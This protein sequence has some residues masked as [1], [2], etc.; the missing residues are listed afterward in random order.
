MTNKPN[1]N[2]NTMVEL[3]GKLL[4]G[5]NSVSGVVHVI[6]D[7]SEVDKFREGEILVADTA[8]P[9]WGDVFEMARGIIVEFSDLH[10]EVGQVAQA[11]DLPVIVGVVDATIHLRSGDIIAMHTD[12]T[13]ERLT[14]RREPD[15]PMRVSV[16][17]AVTARQL[18]GQI[19]TDPKV[20]ALPVRNGDD[21]E[22]SDQKKA[23]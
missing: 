19:I 10:S 16:P 8:E 21:E 20:V 3:A 17:A 7:E 15:S 11:R 13:I 4:S 9:R 2:D 14:E 1:N 6:R 23:G 12:G 22:L 5:G 18:A